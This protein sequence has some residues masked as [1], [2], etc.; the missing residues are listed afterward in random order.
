MKERLRSI[1][2]QL[3]KRHG[4]KVAYKIGKLLVRVSL[5]IL[6]VAFKT[7]IFLFTL[8]IMKG[9][10]SSYQNSMGFNRQ[11]DSEADDIWKIASDSDYYNKEPPGPFN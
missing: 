6:R 8:L 5:I 1:A 11:E 4:N 3:D 9:S 7:C 10:P 2:A